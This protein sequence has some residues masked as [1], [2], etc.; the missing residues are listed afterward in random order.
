[1]KYIVVSVFDKAAAAYSP[2]Q[3]AL[4]PG[5]AVR[6]FEDVI[7]GPESVFSRHS[8]HFELYQ[9]GVWDDADGSFDSSVPPFILANGAS[10][11]ISG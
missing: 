8:E 7:N 4:A 5:L 10:V 2:P 6:Q 3:F 9:L 11:R 1:M